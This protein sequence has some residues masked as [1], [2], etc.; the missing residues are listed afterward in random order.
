MRMRRNW[1]RPKVRIEER[2][3]GLVQLRNELSM[4]Q[5]GEPWPWR[6]GMVVRW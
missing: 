1:R 4:R 5:Y 6:E 2:W 3:I